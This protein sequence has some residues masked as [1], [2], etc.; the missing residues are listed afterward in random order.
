MVKSSAKNVDPIIRAVGGRDEG[1][2]WVLSE[3]S[4][5]DIGRSSENS[6]VLRDRT[7]SKRHS[8]VEK[9]DEIWFISDLSSRHGTL[10]NGEIINQKK[11]L[12]HGDTIKIGE[13]VLVYEE[14]EN[15]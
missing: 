2:R 14:E 3:A 5:H 10:V 6:I 12:F 1:K 4:F 15:D 13:S 9:K 11:G 7:V 8:L